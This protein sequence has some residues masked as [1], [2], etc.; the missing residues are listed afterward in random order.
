M[1]A[2]SAALASS[3]GVSGNATQSPSSTETMS[4]EQ[5]DNSQVASS[6]VKSSD[7]PN[8][9]GDTEISQEAFAKTL[10]K[11]NNLVP[12]PAR[13]IIACL[14]IKFIRI[15]TIINDNF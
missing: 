10:D 4:Q 11:G 14:I 1:F 13:G 5:T 2:S 6:S 8:E 12:R 15:S 9:L 7:Q 3:F